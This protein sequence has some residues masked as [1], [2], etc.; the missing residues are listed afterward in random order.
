MTLQIFA[1]V[2]PIKSGKDTTADILIENGI[3][4]GKLSFAGPLKKICSTVFNIPEEHFHN[5]ILKET[6]FKKPIEINKEHLESLINEMSEY[7]KT[8]VDFSHHEGYLLK[9]P[10]QMLQYIGTEVIRSHNPDFHINAA[11]SDKVVGNL[12]GIYCVTDARFPN[13]YKF[14]ESK[15]GSSFKGFYIQRSDAENRL[16]ESE[17]SSEKNILE[18]KNLVQTILTN[19]ES[20]EEYKNKI[21]T[22]FDI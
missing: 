5:Q 4:N 15:F 16:L 2:G 1:F 13:E 17:H 14:L 3:A 22:L 7:V 6:E 12:S 21:L 9:S 8:E 18:V 20:L 19:E 11:F 10:R